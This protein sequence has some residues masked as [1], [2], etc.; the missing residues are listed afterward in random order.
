ME[1][2]PNFNIISD[3]LQEASNGLRLCQNLPTIQ[4]GQAIADALWQINERLGLLGTRVDQ[5][6]TRV[7]QLGIGLRREMAAR[8]VVDCVIR[9]NV[10]VNFFLPGIKTPSLG[11]ITA[12]W[13]VS[14]TCS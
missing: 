3:H 8:Y 5:L 6:G 9:G 7:D 1:Q 13:F 10:I 4:G 14:R 11:F 12:L 2:Q